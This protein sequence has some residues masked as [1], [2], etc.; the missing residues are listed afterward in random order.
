MS[1]PDTHL[2]QVAELP[3]ALGNFSDEVPPA[4]RTTHGM[5]TP[6]S[7]LAPSPASRA[8]PQSWVPQNGACSGPTHSLLEGGGPHFLYYASAFWVL[9]AVHTCSNLPTS[10]H[11]R[12]C[13]LPYLTGKETE[14]R[15][16]QVLKPS[17]P[18]CCL[19][20]LLR[21]PSLPLVAQK[22]GSKGGDR[23]HIPPT[24]Y[25]LEAKWTIH[26]PSLPPP[27]FRTIRRC[28][29]GMGCSKEQSQRQTNNHHSLC[30][31]RPHAKR[32]IYVP[33][34][35]EIVDR[36]VKRGLLSPHLMDEETGGPARLSR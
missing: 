30:A 18:L 35:P 4:P 16:G 2:V 15:G 17:L 12:D 19:E 3:G 34:L 7:F 32:F 1:R 27:P 14:A 36:P 31:P 8:R 9:S 5:S 20:R 13:H 6:E 21:P 24:S 11:G 26:N 33:S 29:E 28:Q 23:S 22:G 25:L 10:S